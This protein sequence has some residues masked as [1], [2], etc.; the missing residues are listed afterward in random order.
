MTWEQYDQLW[1][2]L[3]DSFAED[4]DNLYGTEENNYEGWVYERDELQARLDVTNA[5][6]AAEA[7][8]IAQEAA[9]AEAA[10][11]AQI[12]K[13]RAEKAAAEKAAKEAA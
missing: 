1:I 2:E 3:D 5:A 10:R 6:A 11:L 4:F 7:D 13:E 8:R 9:I 12:E